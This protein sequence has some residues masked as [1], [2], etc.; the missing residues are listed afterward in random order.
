MAEGCGMNCIK[1]LVFIF[2][3]LFAVSI[4]LPSL[5]GFGSDDEWVEGNNEESNFQL[6]FF[7]VSRVLPVD[8]ETIK[9]SQSTF[10]SLFSIASKCLI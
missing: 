10:R 1:Y 9:D 4:W 2:N 3:F 7:A 5:N 6:N 8:V